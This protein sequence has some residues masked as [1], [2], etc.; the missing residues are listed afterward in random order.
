MLSTV[1]QV[2]TVRKSFPHWRVD[3]GAQRSL[4]LR[5]DDIRVLAVAASESTRPTNSLSL[6]ARKAVVTAGSVRD[7]P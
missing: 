2:H 7:G 5:G 1:E 4:A 3:A 6:R